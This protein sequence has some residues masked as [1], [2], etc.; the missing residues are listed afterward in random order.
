M[1]N[2]ENYENVEIMRVVEKIKSVLIPNRSLENDDV[3]DLMTDM[4]KNGRCWKNRGRIKDIKTAPLVRSNG[5]DC[6]KKLNVFEISISYLTVT[7]RVIVF[8]TLIRT[9]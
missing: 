5:W 8:P 7:L 6:C 4:G 2:F 9:T 3:N 1:S